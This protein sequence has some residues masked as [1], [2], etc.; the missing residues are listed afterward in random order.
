[1]NEMKIKF[2]YNDLEFELIICPSQFSYKHYCYISYFSSFNGFKNAYIPYQ[3]NQLL[4]D[5]RQANYRD[6]IISDKLKRV[7]EKYIKLVNFA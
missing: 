6:I 2:N 3:N 5:D 7:I 4:W 1:M